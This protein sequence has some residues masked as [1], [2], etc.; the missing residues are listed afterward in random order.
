LV[1]AGLALVADI[2]GGCRELAVGTNRKH[3]DV[4]GAV[5]RDEYVF[6]GFVE[7][8]IARILAQRRKLIQQR[9]L[10]ALRINRKRAYG[11]GLARFV[12]RVQ[13]LSAGMHHH[14]RR[15]PCLR[16]EA[17]RRYLPN[18]RIK[19]VR[20]NSFALR[21]GR[22]RP[23]EN[24]IFTTCSRLVRRSACNWKNKETK[25][26]NEGKNSACDFHGEVV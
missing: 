12:R 3:H 4:A 15:V 24:K 8:Q 20:V 22:V 25:E 10:P 14:P 7:R 17:L 9:K 19:L 21:F 26:K 6:A 23:N 13:K 1:G 18:F 5:I 2:R 16:R 11:A